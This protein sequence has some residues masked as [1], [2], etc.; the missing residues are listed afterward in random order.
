MKNSFKLLSI[1]LIII[2]NVS[3]KAEIITTYSLNSTTIQ[4]I[5]KL[6]DEDTVVFVELDDVLVRP[7]SKMFD[8]GDNPHRL[9]IDSLVA[10]AMENSRYLN[11]IATWYQ[12][13]KIRLVED[14]WQ[15]FINNL[16]KRKIPV[17][18]LCFMP[19][20]LQN[21]E[22]KRFLELKDLGIR[23]TDKIDGK[24]V[25]EIA[26]KEKWASQFYYGII[27]TGPFTKAQTLVDLMKITNI[28]PKK[29]VV[30]DKNEYDLKMIEKAFYRFRIDF[31]SIFYWGAKQ[32]TQM[33]DPNIVGLQQKMLF[34]K[35]KW[36]EDNEAAALLKILP[37]DNEQ[38]GKN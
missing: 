22:Q 30:F 18:G 32:F 10:L 27:F 19:I 5:D 12:M 7:Q 28:S 1:I 15:D 4:K 20:Q 9:F 6:I 25:I 3:A 17:Y 21:I 13:R 24:N 36:L 16:K 34:E 38:V 33:P 31:Y 11:Q 8:Y 2:F 23:F 35:N 37:K 14:G 26:K 29:I